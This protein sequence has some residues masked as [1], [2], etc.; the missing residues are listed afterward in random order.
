[1]CGVVPPYLLA[2]DYS[3]QINQLKL[4]SELREGPSVIGGLGLAAT[5]VS[6]VGPQLD[7]AHY[8]PVQRL[9]RFLQARRT[10]S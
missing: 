6:P 9:I 4:R 7:A 1:M 5:A 8:D 2:W 10:L 3:V